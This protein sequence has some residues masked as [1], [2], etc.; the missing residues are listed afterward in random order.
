MWLMFFYV[1]FHSTMNAWSELMYFADREFYKDWWN[2]CS[3]SYFWRNWNIPIYRFCKRFFYFLYLI[4][5]F[6]HI[7]F[8]IVE[9]GYSH[10]TA[11]IIV[12][13]ISAFFHE[14]FLISF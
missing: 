13:F 10:N 9:S 7:Y 2:S 11:S 4:L 3:V 1:T 5:L 14:V 6:R 8:P 12:F